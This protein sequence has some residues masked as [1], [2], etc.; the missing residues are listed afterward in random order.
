MAWVW[1][2]WIG[3]AVVLMLFAGWLGVGLT[4]AGGL[5]ILIDTRGRFSLSQ[6]QLV[7]WTIVV[8]SLMGGVFIGRLKGGAGATALSFDIPANLLLVMGI[9]V[10]SA[11]GAAAT[12]SYKDISAP[13]RIAASIPAGQQTAAI[14]AAKPPTPFFGQMF[15]VEEGAMADQ[16]IDITK[17]QN[18]WITLILIVAYVAMVAAYFAGLDDPSKITQL[19]DFSSQMVVLL[20]ISHGGYFVGKIPDRQGNAP[21]SMGQRNLALASRRV[22]IPTL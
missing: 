5:G 6:F 13:Q 1:G 16:V 7:L 2:G 18:F 10:G 14:A 15:L 21:Y 22:E 17:F 12:K 19:P 3:T 11:I 8:L 9:S 4:K 20:A